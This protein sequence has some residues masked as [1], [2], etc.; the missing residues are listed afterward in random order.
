M[1]ARTTGV[2]ATRLIGG[3]LVL[4]GAAQL[5]GQVLPFVEFMSWLN[6]NPRV[7]FENLSGGSQFGLSANII[8]MAIVSVLLGWYLLFRGRRV[9][10]W[11]LAGLGSECEKCGY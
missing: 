9:H 2:I 6:W 11:L 4:F 10:A 3:V 7:I 8:C 1:S 5:L